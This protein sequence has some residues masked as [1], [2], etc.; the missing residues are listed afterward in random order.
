MSLRTTHVN[1]VYNPRVRR[2]ALPLRVRML[3]RRGGNRKC[4]SRSCAYDLGNAPHSRNSAPAPNRSQGSWRNA[5]LACLSCFALPHSLYLYLIYSALRTLAVRPRASLSK[6]ARFVEGPWFFK[7][8]LTFMMVKQRHCC[9][10]LLPGQ[11]QWYTRPSYRCCGQAKRS[12]TLGEGGALVVGSI[13]VG[14]RSRQAAVV[15]T[16]GEA[17]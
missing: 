14:L 8:S 11:A 5:P 12:G 13:I 2:R 3:P 9:R 6:L 15:C 17:R 10:C 7:L 1:T 16:G 4:S